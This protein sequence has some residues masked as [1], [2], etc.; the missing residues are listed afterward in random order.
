MRS[1]SSGSTARR[2]SRS[3][4]GVRLKDRW[5]DGP[6][7][8]WTGLQ[9]RDAD[10]RRRSML[11]PQAGHADSAPRTPLAA[12]AGASDQPLPL[13]A[14]DERAASDIPPE[15]DALEQAR[16][17]LAAGETS[18]AGTAIRALIAREPKNAPA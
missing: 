18:A 17:L 8:R 13:D 6:M 4:D 14:A 2:R 5:T 12:E 7:D 11:H 15:P 3:R 9:F 10:R 1:T 16:E